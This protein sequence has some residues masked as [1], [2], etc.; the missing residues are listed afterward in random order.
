MATAGVALV[1][2]VCV[3]ALVGW[4][5]STVATNI[6]IRAFLTI[7]VGIAGAIGVGSVLEL[8]GLAAWGVITVIMAGIGALGLL[9]ML[10]PW[11]KT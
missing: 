10:R 2:F 5:A 3:G 4:F 1:S 8:S 7:L 6:D 9:L 11:G